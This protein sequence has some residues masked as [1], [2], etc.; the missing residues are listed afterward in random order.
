MDSAHTRSND[1]CLSE[2]N[3]ACIQIEEDT[4]LKVPKNSMLYCPNICELILMKK[5]SHPNIMSM[6]GIVSNNNRISIRMCRYRSN[7][8]NYITDSSCT[9]TDIVS[10]V[11]RIVRALCYLHSLEL[12]HGDLHLCNVLVNSPTDIT[13]SDLGSSRHCSNIKSKRIIYTSR[14]PEVVKGSY[15]LSS[16]IWSLGI[17]LYEALYIMSRRDINKCVTHIDTISCSTSDQGMYNLTPEHGVIMNCIRRSSLAKE[18]LICSE[19]VQP[20]VIKRCMLTSL[21]IIFC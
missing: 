9:I 12:Y 21:Y 10:M 20:A 17:L 11:T 4:V 3:S 5:V 6:D 18:H 15:Y 1:A 16:D 8:K 13:V 19:G 14:A 2:G 7:M